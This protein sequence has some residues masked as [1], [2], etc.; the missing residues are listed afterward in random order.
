MAK[1]KTLAVKK[2]LQ[3]SKRKTMSKSK[4][5][6]TRKTAHHA[7]NLPPAVLEWFNKYLRYV[8]YIG[9]A[10][11]YLKENCLIKEELKP[12]HIKERILGHWGTVPGLSFIYAHLNYLI[13]K[14]KASMMY[15]AG[16]GHGAPAVI[17]NLFAENT[18]AE[19]YPQLKRNNEGT[20]N[21][22]HMFSWPG[23]FPSHTNPG[24]PGAILEGGELGYSLAT[25]FGAVMDNPDLIVTCV[26]GDGEAETGPLATAWHGNKFLNP[27][28]SG[29]VLPILHANGYKITG[30]TIFAT[31]SDEELTHLFTGYGYEPMIVSCEHITSPEA[32]ADM[33]AALETAY[34]RIR[35]IQKK[36]RSSKKPYLKPKWPMIVFRSPKGDTGIKKADG[37]KVAGLYYAHGIP[38]NDP[39]TNPEHFQLVKHWLESYHFNELLDSKGQPLPEV[40]TYVPKGN[41][42]M[43]KN[44]HANGGEM[45][46]ALKLPPIK[47]YAVKVTKRGPQTMSSNTAVSAKMLRDVIKLNPKNFRFMCPDETES[48]KFMDLFQVTERA[49]MWPVHEY[50]ESVGPNGR[51]ME[52]LSEHNLQGWLQGYL[53]TGRHGIFVTYE[54]FATIVASMVDQYAK[55]LKQSSKVKW[56]KPVASLNYLLTSVG[57]RQEH[58]GFSHQNPS[59][60]S[61]V[62]EKHGKFCSVYFPADANSMLAIMED[63]LKRTNGINVIVAGKNPLPQWL[64][65]EEAR[66]ELKTG[67]GVWNWVDPEGTKDPDI[68]M[69]AT[70][71]ALVQESMAAI[72]LL[73]ENVPELKTRFVNVSELTALG[74]G[75]ERHPLG[76]DNKKFEEI[77][78]TDKPIIYNFHGYTGVIKKLIFGHEHAERFSIHGYNEE[79]TTTT[80]FEMMVLNKSSRFHLAIEVLQKASKSNPAVAAKAPT[81]IK[82]FEQL[83]ADHEIY[84]RKFGKDNPEVDNW[85]WK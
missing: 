39:R 29:A 50:D 77:F 45:L 68:V 53:L 70:G 10:Q 23:G 69:A 83:I 32:H 67:I 63:C 66:E 36:A 82:R 57:W 81:V 1:K 42:R 12:E 44:K 64:T 65:L 85:Q 73:K 56:R 17:A 59:F 7:K 31:M 80:P 18:L 58:N 26:V 48:N 30:P 62:L 74:I 5:Q 2:T 61:N 25:S 49:Y 9:A 51:V 27:R 11:L 14:H 60:V 41:L 54:A 24:T 40:L 15:I 76:I 3:I 19:Y 79:G 47:N 38:I 35:A 75:D 52:V 46:K 84:I 13:S 6:A 8:N 72:Q 33:D 22:I 21:L 34:K 43:G 55:F 37:H 20:S 28:T 78:T 16:P 4:K 71:D